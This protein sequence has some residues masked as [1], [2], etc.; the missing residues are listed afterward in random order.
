MLQMYQQRLNDI[1]KMYMARKC[2]LCDTVS[3]A[4]RTTVVSSCFPKNPI[5]TVT[6]FFLDD[7]RI[8]GNGANHFH[9]DISSFNKFHL[10]VNIYLNT[11]PNF[12]DTLSISFEAGGELVSASLLQPHTLEITYAVTDAA[13]KALNVRIS[14]QGV[15][16]FPD[17]IY[18]PRLEFAN[19][20]QC[21]CTLMPRLLDGGLITVSP[22]TKMFAVYRYSEKH[23]RPECIEIYEINGLSKAMQSLEARLLYP[24][25][26]NLLAWRHCRFTRAGTIIG[27]RCDYP[28]SL[29]EVTFQN[30]IIRIFPY[31]NV[32]SFDVCQES[33]C[34]AYG[35]IKRDSSRVFLVDLS[36]GITKCTLATADAADRKSN[37]VSVCLSQSGKFV[38]ESWFDG[39]RETFTRVY[40]TETGTLRKELKHNDS[41]F[42]TQFVSDNI[43][44]ITSYFTEKLVDIDSGKE[45]PLLPG[46]KWS[47][48]GSPVVQ[49]PYAFGIARGGVLGVYV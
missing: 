15:P 17:P 21:V 36:T 11:V 23:V 1:N 46:I 38:C 39:R 35:L 4:N 7:C 18:I 41:D 32:V 48:R 30:K 22:D 27:F 47:L 2:K 37:T 13:A 6:D 20:G 16:V 12:M 34:L 42:A 14:C 29:V 25:I 19:L 31:E 26:T 24:E 28:A 49:A 5:I 45:T 9:S 3:L 43:L 10:H 44:H 40:C 33:N 8:D